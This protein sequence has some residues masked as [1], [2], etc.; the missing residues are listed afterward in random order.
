MGIPVRVELP[1]TEIEDVRDLRVWMIG[2]IPENA[3][4]SGTVRDG[5]PTLV[6]TWER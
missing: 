3:K 4:I 1:L 6:F 2:R 5:T